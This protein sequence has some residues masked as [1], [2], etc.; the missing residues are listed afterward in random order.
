VVSHQAV[1]THLDGSP[2]YTLVTDLAGAT[3]P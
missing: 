3:L 1:V 2:D